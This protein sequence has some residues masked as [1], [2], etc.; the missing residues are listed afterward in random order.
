MNVVTENKD[1]VELK[2]GVSDTGI[3]ISDEIQAKLF[4]AFTQ[5]DG[6]TTRKYG[7]TGLGLAIVKQ[8]VEKME[9]SYGV[10]SELDKG[11][12]FWV[13]IPFEKSAEKLDSLNEKRSIKLEGLTGKV[14]LVEDNPVNQ[15]VAS[16]MLD[17]LGLTVV[18]AANG[19][20][21]VDLLKEE[22]F[23]AVLIDCQMPVMD[24]FE[25]TRCL[26][27]FESNV[28]KPPVPVIAMTAN[29]MQGDKELCLEAGMDDYLGK[30]VK[31]DQLSEKLQ[32][33]LY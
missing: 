21:A 2:I 8:L 23:N 9:G 10:E 13:S 28:A 7:G 26:R 18:L 12:L 14:L 6:S 32:K 17:T 30:P 27:E 5:A 4:T 20:E 1:T 15:M 3:G 16:K 11:A 29:V 22:E 25:A 19:Q 31:L 24:G 33:W